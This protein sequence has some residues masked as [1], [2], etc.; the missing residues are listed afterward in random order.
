M[1]QKSGSQAVAEQPIPGSNVRPADI[2]LSGWGAKPLAVGFTVVTPGRQSSVSSCTSSTATSIMDQA[3]RAKLNKS[4]APCNTDNW[5]FEPFVADT[6]G[7]LSSDARAMIRHLINRRHQ[8]FEPLTPAETGRAFWST[9][10]GAVVSRAA[11]QLNR[12]ALIDRPLGMA[13][14]GLDLLTG[15]S[16]TTRQSTSS[17]TAIATQQSDM[18]TESTKLPSQQCVNDVFMQVAGDDETEGAPATNTFLGTD[19]ATAL[20]LPPKR[21]NT[22][23]QPFINATTRYTEA[24]TAKITQKLHICVR[25]AK[26][27]E[28]VPIFHCTTRNHRGSEEHHASYLQHQHALLQL[29]L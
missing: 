27:G 10:T 9:L 14:D 13:F 24:K 28:A 8:R 21:P 5:D 17:T 15:R 23:W 22:A 16:A 11:M 18:G 25:S 19:D 20:S 7:T 12:H 4:R 3:T 26:G 1:F 6:Y 29:R 2:L